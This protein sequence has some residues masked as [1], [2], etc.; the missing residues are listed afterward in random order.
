M[1]GEIEDI[2]GRIFGDK[3]SLDS[4]I[5]WMCLIMQEFGYTIQDMQDMPIPTFK[6]LITYLVEQDKQM[7]KNLKKSGGK[8]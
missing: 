4:E 7:K 5:L 3:H 8:K 2:R 6:I 1:A